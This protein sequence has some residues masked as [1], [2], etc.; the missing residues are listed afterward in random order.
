MKLQL[1][2]TCLALGALAAAAQAQSNDARVP[3]SP[4]QQ[5]QAQQ[6][7]TQEAQVQSSAGLEY[8][9]QKV[10]PL[11]IKRCFECHSAESEKSNGGLRL[12]DRQAILTGGDN[13]PAAIEG[14]VSESLILRAVHYTE[15]GFEMP[16][17][18][19]LP[20][21][22]IE[23]LERWVE[24]G[25]P[26]PSGPAKQTGKRVIDIEA[27]R[28]HWAFQPLMESEPS[29]DPSGWSRGRIDAYIAASQTHKQLHPLPQATPDKLFRRI[30]FDL[31][32]CHPQ[33]T[34]SPATCPIHRL[35]RLSGILICG[36]LRHVMASAGD[37]SG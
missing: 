31:L 32:G 2:L 24:L 3:E 35:Q 7:Q 16:P 25:L 37:A 22:E 27:G 18:G 33:P 4:I 6:D 14:K 23:V 30:K 12:D 15:P 13:G 8:F 29:T 11:L 26:M 1:A 17:T 36:W 34:S 19:K 20:Q 21:G 10:R 28:K 9:E 5:N